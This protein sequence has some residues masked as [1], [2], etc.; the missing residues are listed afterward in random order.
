MSTDT[1]NVVEE[2]KS[3]AV[4]ELKKCNTK[5]ITPLIVLSSTAIIAIF[6]YFQRYPVGD[7]FVIV[8]ASVVVFL[9]IGLIVEK[10]ITKFVDIN[11]EK[12]VAEIEEA[13]RLEEEARA[14]MEAEGAEVGDGLNVVPEEEENPPL[15]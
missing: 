5:L 10:M 13:K 9:I 6:T 4:D 8:C 2:K 12:A 7:W 3:T 15:F 1:E 11:Y 14:A